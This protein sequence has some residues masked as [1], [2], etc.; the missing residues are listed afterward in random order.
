MPALAPEHQ[1]QRQQSFLPFPE[2]V[3]TNNNNWQMSTEPRRKLTMYARY[4]TF[5]SGPQHRAAIEQV[6]DTMRSFLQTLDGFVSVT[7]V[8]S[9]DQTTYGSFSTWVSREAAENAGA[10]IMEKLP[11]MLA[12][13]AT[14]PPEVVLM[15][16]YQPAI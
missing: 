11:P 9:E 12:D 3:A 10:A 7:F 16:V 4:L 13:K 1:I 14:A 8:V 15:E 2:P 5:K 6:A